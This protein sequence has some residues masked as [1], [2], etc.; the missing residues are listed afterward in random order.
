MSKADDPRISGTNSMRSRQSPQPQLLAENS[1]SLPSEMIAAHPDMQSDEQ[2]YDGRISRNSSMQDLS[3]LGVSHP[4]LYQGSTSLKSF[5]VFNEPG[6]TMHID[7]KE[8]KVET[9]TQSLTMEPRSAEKRQAVPSM[10]FIQNFTVD[11]PV[12]TSTPS[13]SSVLDMDSDRNNVLG[14][15]YYDV[16]EDKLDSVDLFLK[17]VSA[18]LNILIRSFR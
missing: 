15:T 17:S 8:P 14:R 18:F 5:D 12:S 13:V 16:T 3:K 4:D 10:E 1:L 2:N 9:G 6:F 11:K 7:L